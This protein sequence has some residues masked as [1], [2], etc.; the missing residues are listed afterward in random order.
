MSGRRETS[1]RR[2]LIGAL[3]AL[4]LL[5]AG[6]LFLYSTLTKPLRPVAGA[7]AG[8]PAFL[9]QIFGVSKTDPFNKP[10]DVA[11]DRRGNIYVTDTLNDRILIFNSRGKFIGGFPSTVT[12]PLG[13]DIDAGGNVY[14]VSKRGDTVAVYDRSGKL[15]RQYEAFV[16]LDVAV[17]S[18]KVYITT[19]GPIIVY[20]R[21]GEY[22]RDFIGWH[23]REKE[24]FAWPNGITVAPDG[25][26]YVADTNNLRVKAL[27]ANGTLKWV[28][29]NPPTKA[30]YT[31]AEGRAFGA[32]AGIASDEDGNIFLVDGLRDR[33]YVYSTSHKLLTSWGDRGDAE[34]LF[35]HPAGIAY[36]GSGIVYVVDKF[37]NRV[38][39]FRVSLPGA[40]LA[41]RRNLWWLALLLL[42]PLLPLLLRRRKAVAVTE[43]AF[44]EWAIQDEWAVGHSALGMLKDQFGVLWVA[45]EVYDAYKERAVGTVSFADLLRVGDYRKDVAAKAARDFGVDKV[46]ARTIAIGQKR[47][48]RALLLTDDA[49][50]REIAVDWDIRTVNHEELIALYE[51]P[52]AEHETAPG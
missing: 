5:L 3:I 48:A 38:Q 33:V 30:Q 36:G 13:I 27:K 25:T 52:E 46:P 16:P 43:P 2:F 4:L 19:I 20:D 49:Q 6:L 44:L 39:A 34:G 37:N 47:K 8:G 45:Q 9:F 28:L 29:G 18:R 32:P 26:L 17:T 14:V 23:G 41:A 35:D 15:L 42:L 11:V 1:E 24:N 40:G 50:L 31:Q 7:K 12:R 51:A 22:D 10:T 21:R